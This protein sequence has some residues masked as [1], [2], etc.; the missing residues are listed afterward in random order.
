MN[1]AL[2]A[3]DKLSIRLAA[4]DTARTVVAEASFEVA[5]G[6][7]LGIVGES[8]SGKTLS[9]LSLVQLLPQGADAR[10]TRAV[11]ERRNLLELSR[12][13]LDAVRG[14]EIAFIFQ[15]PLTAL[16]PVL[17]VGRQIG[18]VMRR[19]FQLSSAEAARRAIAL[20][21]KVGIPDAPLRLRQ[22]PHEFSGGMRQRVTIAMALAGEPR[23]L[24]ADEP[25]TALDV[26]VQAEIVNLI[27]SVQRESG[28][29]VIWVT[30]DL[31]LLARIADRVLVMYRGRVVEDAPIDRLF[32]APE[33]PYTRTL[34]GHLRTDG[35]RRGGPAVGTSEGL[36]PPVE[37]LLAARGITVSYARKGV[38]PLQS[39]RRPVMALDGVDLDIRK[40]ETLAL[41]GESGSGK[42]TLARVLVR[43]IEPSAGTVM[44]R[45]AD[46]SALEGGAL[47]AVR[48]H[49]QIIFQDPFSS[50]NP[51]RSIG[52]AIAEPLIV[53]DLARGRELK[54]RV[55]ACL[56][57]VG[58]DGALADRHPHEF[59]GG[60]RQRI[61]I[62]RAIACRPDFIVA[63]EALSALDMSLQGQILDL[64]QDLKERFALTYLFISHDLSVVRR[65]SDRVAVLYLG[66]LVELAPTA[67]LYDYPR[68][69]Y[70]R[71]LLAAVP[72]PDPTLERQRRYAP[73]AGEPPSP[74][75][76]PPGCPLHPRCPR[77]QDR[78][79]TELP[80]LTEIAAGRVVACHYPH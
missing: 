36:A 47:R 53:H 24:I 69:P 26:T 55:A 44:F 16:N 10:A 67:E 46:I 66:R 78:C 77:A 39:R 33:H 2:L 30:H 54:E 6:E 12:S 37:V 56:A 1:A 70:T 57:M 64:F 13:Q 25:T 40:G 4:R 50:L 14:R 51:R 9:M 42:S 27:K 5:A 41:V 34:L 43:T 63:D 48:R 7:T 21:A 29:T 49:L 76:P 28:M 22:F 17:S 45:G 61:C 73:L 8:G 35:E 75:N 79:R 31:A 71:A 65:S 52:A 23:L 18:E 58:L 80:A 19:H 60:Q 15:D 68:H 3:V 20:L 32:A 72:I 11:F 74:A 38:L 62:A 59:S